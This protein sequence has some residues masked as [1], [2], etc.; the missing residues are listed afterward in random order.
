[1]NRFCT[2]S[3]A[4]AVALLAATSIPAETAAPSVDPMR[5]TLD[6]VRTVGA[7]LY[8][9]DRDQG[10][11]RA[12]EPAADSLPPEADLSQI[13]VLSAKELEALLVP[14]YLK[15]LELTDGWGR[16]LEVR[17]RKSVV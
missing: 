15:S 17:D 16:A 8:A 5:E 3:L 11:W 9:W 14:R 4:A 10:A 13:A 6:S 12:G 2:A 1:M 7:A